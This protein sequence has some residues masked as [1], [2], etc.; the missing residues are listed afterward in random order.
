MVP[1]RRSLALALAVVALSTAP[2]RA[3]TLRDAMAAA[4]AT[5]HLMNAA[6]DR[7]AAA[8][9]GIDR[10]WSGFR[11]QVFING[12]AERQYLDR[13]LQN[14][15]TGN[16]T[17]DTGSLEL[18][19]SQRLFDGGRVFAA[20]RQAE[21]ETETE[22]ARMVLQE[23]D[24]LDDAATVYMDV[25]QSTT[26]VGYSR[27][28]MEV[29]GELAAATERRFD[30]QEATVTDV[31]QARSRLAAARA[32]L[33]DAENTVLAARATYIRV[34]GRPPADLSMPTDLPALPT[35]LEEALQVALA[36]NPRL[37]IAA[38]RTNTVE[39]QLDGAQ[40]DLLPLVQLQ[41]FLSEERYGGDTTLDRDTTY[42]G[43]VV[44]NVPLYE[45]GA[46]Q[47]RIRQLKYSKS[48]F[49]QLTL[50]EREL[51][52]ESV[53]ATWD[54]LQTARTRRGIV[55][56]QLAE[57]QTALEALRREYV[58][59][60]RL[61]IDVLDGEFDVLQAQT[62]LARTQRDVV[63]LTYRLLGAIGRLSVERLD[64]AAAGATSG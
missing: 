16:Q 20:V 35:S 58:T 49:T 3:E 46:T 42:G 15:Q 25:V 12:E 19:V 7:A 22:K 45:G 34:V 40:A 50:D 13:N 62:S 55:E 54:A 24:V 6:G 43:R 21:A 17:V 32:S 61:L 37:A 63:V 30:L 5:S 18:N 29:I 51:V 2:V 53:V 11:P 41:G 39:A 64:L 48:Q 1:T 8:A 52:Q 60:T 56:V 38:A 26:I 57:A 27:R 10:A 31:A 36:E 44:L 4:V 23:Q 14:G 28:Y 9:E 47:A 33:A 59:G